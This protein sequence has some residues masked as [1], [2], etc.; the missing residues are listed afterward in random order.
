MAKKKGN[1]IEGQFVPLPHNLLL[2]KAYM[3]LSNSEKV[4]LNYFLID[5][6]NYH[7]TQ[8]ILTFEQ[9][10]KYEVCQSPSTF[11][12]S[13]QGLVDKGFI[14]TKEP[15]GLGKCST[16]IISDRWKRYGTN[17]YKKVLFKPGVGSKYFK[18]IWNDDTKR[19]NLLE[20]RHRKKT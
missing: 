13:K 11:L 18:T 6:K 9:A 19:K 17:E 2:S 16:F 15:G 1:K 4:T 8:V 12:K 5:K 7:Q 14:D 10:K 20:A 3:S